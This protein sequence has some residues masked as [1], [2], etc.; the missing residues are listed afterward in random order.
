MICAAE[1]ETYYKKQ[2]EDE[3]SDE[4]Q[5]QKPAPLDE[6]FVAGVSSNGPA[7]FARRCVWCFMAER[8]M[9]YC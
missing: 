8:K 1:D 2:G 5:A 4:D 9:F 3:P 6:T 7:V